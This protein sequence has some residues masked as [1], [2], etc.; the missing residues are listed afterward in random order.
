MC[1]MFPRAPGPARGLRRGLHRLH[2]DQHGSISVEAMLMLP[3]YI[4]CFL[5]T[6]VFFD[7]YRAQ[8][9]NNKAGYTIADILS[10]ETGYI[11][12]Q[13]LDSLHDL[14]AFLVD[15][16]DPIRLRVSVIAYD[17]TG[18]AYSVRWSQNRGGG[19]VLETGDLPAM[20][21]MIPEMA[22]GAIAIVVQTSMVYEPAY[23]SGIDILNFDDFVVTRPRFSGQ[24][25]Y[26][27]VN[28]DPTEQTATC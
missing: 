5:G 18:D 14:Q 13:Y 25:C 4:W 15:R 23:A 16:R 12:P 2:R 22:D 6:W 17:E 3:F 26:N 1:R 19:G 24:M 27:S 7:A 11:T 21:T 20:R 10:R 8:F 9:V 28:I